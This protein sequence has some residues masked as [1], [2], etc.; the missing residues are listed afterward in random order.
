M[1]AAR[2]DEGRWFEPGR[3]G[4][5]WFERAEAH[6]WRFALRGALEAWPAWL[7]ALT[8]EERAEVMRYQRG[9]D[10]ER[11]LISRGARRQLV[12]EACGCAPA[13]V[14]FALGPHGKPEC[15]PRA[16]AALGRT[17]EFNVAHSGA[18]VVVALSK[19]GAVGVDVEQHREV[20]EAR[21]VDACFSAGE[22]AAWRALAAERR[23]AGFYALWTRKEAYV[24][25]TGAGLGKPLDRFSVTADPSETAKVRV[26]DEDDPAAAERWTFWPVP[27]D[28]AHSA[29]LVTEG[30]VT[31]IGRWDWP[32]A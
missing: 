19:E 10:R 26:E 5:A 2:S 28:A 8:T 1:N 15:R 7:A 22:A 6:V 13:D 25:A 14:A 20:D 18:W 11:A 31:S 9:E 32:A 21:L 27:M 12:A 3:P 17:V 29:A 24:K 30:N 23:T 4:S 16:G